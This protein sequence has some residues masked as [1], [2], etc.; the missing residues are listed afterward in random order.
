MSKYY[1]ADGPNNPPGALGYLLHVLDTMTRLPD[2][3]ASRM[4][5]HA[6]EEYEKTYDSAEALEQNRKRT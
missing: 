5:K 6:L 3:S 2:S 1:G 4:A